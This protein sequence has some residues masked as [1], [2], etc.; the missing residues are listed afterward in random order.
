MQEACQDVD[1]AE[2]ATTALESS[3]R[4]SR[5]YSGGRQSDGVAGSASAATF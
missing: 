1:R 3:R 2:R 5:V 4:A